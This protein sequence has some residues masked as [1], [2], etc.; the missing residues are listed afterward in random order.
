MIEQRDSDCEVI[1][2]FGTKF[3]LSVDLTVTVDSKIDGIRCKQ[4]YELIQAKG[5]L[6]RY[7]P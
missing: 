1:V 6:Y 7:I 3:K 2:C 4:K 5:D